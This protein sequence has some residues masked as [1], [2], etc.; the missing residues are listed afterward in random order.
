MCKTCLHMFATQQKAGGK[1]DHGTVRQSLCLNLLSLKP[2]LLYH[3]MYI[4]GILIH[5]IE[6]VNAYICKASR[7]RGQRGSQYRTIILI[8]KTIILQAGAPVTYYVY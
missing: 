2:V 5:S 1:G 3:V 8:L 6:G 7:G 4:G